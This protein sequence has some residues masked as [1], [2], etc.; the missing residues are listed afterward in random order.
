MENRDTPFTIGLGKYDY[1]V[2]SKREIR[3]NRPQVPLLKTNSHPSTRRSFS[4]AEMD[5]ADKIEKEQWQHPLKLAK[6]DMNIVA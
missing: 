5:V 6:I 3:R 2:S 1:M 4:E